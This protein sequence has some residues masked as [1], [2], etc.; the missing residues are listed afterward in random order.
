M[1]LDR[2]AVQDS[3]LN[4]VLNARDAMAGRTGTIRLTARAVRDTWLEIIVDD[5]GPGFS[6][7]ALRRGLDPFFTTKGGEGSG[8]GLAMVFDHASLAGGSVRLGNRPEGGAR[9]TLRLPLMPAVGAPLPDPVLVLLVEDSAE[10]RRQVREML[11]AM[12]HRVIEAETADDALPLAHL[13]EVGLV[14]SDIQ[15]PGGASGLDLVDRLTH[16]RPDL[17]V[18]LMTSL[19]AADALHRRSAARVGVLQ[20]PFS[21]L[22][23]AQVLRGALAPRLA[24]Q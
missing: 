4:L 16:A 8:L 10:L 13:P 12:G 7:E 2:G 21:P 19:P 3:L 14:L 20:K 17:P 1:M 24:A 22:D 23:L 18:A 5:D 9:V 6:D 11:L 15:L